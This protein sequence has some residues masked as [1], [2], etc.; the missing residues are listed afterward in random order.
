MIAACNGWTF[1]PAREVWW[2]KTG[3]STWTEVHGTPDTPPTWS[4]K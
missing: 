3:P 1:D 4:A 2:A